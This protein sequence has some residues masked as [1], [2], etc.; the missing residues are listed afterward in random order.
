[1][2]V[3][4]YIRSSHAQALYVYKYTHTHGQILRLH[5]SFSHLISVPNLVPAKQSTE[6]MDLSQYEQMSFHTVLH[7]M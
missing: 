5:T 6:P 3:Y 1:M 7:F 2:N 4:T